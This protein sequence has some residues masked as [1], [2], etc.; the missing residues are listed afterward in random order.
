MNKTHPATSPEVGLPDPPVLHDGDVHLWRLALDPPAGSL[1]VFRSYLAEDELSRA[2]HYVFAH[3]R[4]RFIAARGYLR[5]ILA[6]YI[7]CFPREVQFGYGVHG[8]PHL[9]ASTMGVAALEFNL[10]HTRGLGLCAVARDRRVGV[11]VEQARP[12]VDILGIARSTFSA[13]EHARL[14]ALPP[15]QHVAA[16]YA[17][18]T[19]K[20]AYIKARGEGLSYPLDAFDVSFEPDEPVALLRSVEGQAEQQRWTLRAVDVGE[21]YAA[22]L[23]VERPVTRLD[24]LAWS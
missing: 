9:L 13:D 8:K 20:E 6:R 7:G 23:V 3:D 16:F 24:L 4:E 1:E 12:E 15:E 2:Q 5:A 17:C 21:G 10:S 19:R 14:E 22:A 18:W 11:D